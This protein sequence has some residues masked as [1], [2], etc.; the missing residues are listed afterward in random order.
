MGCDVKECGWR[1]AERVT[2]AICVDESQ[3]RIGDGRM[4]RYGPDGGQIPNEP[5]R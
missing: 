3:A 4:Y 5:F 1:D 2:F